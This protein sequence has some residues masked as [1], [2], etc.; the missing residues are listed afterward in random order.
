MRDYVGIPDKSAQGLIRLQVGWKQYQIIAVCRWIGR[1]Q[2]SNDA[3]QT[4]IHIHS[5]HIHSYLRSGP[6]N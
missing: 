1:N 5:F 6:L 4:C 3:I 2:L